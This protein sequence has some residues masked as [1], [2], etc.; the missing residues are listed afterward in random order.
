MH[1]SYILETVF[2]LIRMKACLLIRAEPGKKEHL[3]ERLSEITG[4]K[5]AFP[6]LGRMD[7][8]ANVEVKG[9]KALDDLVLKITKID[10]YARCVTL[11][12]MEI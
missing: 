5:L 6:T 7:V 12:G 3:A 4:V 1:L 10:G 9:L 8:V 2:S 11:I